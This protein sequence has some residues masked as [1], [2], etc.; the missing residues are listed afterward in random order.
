MVACR[1]SVLEALA[2]QLDH[3][4]WAGCSFWDMIQPSFMFLVGVAMPFSYGKRRDRG[5]SWGRLFG[6]AVVRSIVLILLGIFLQSHDKLHTDWTFF[7]V[8]MQI[9]LGYP[10]VFLVL[11]LH[12][13]FQLLAACAILGADWAIFA[14]YVPKS[15]FE[16]HWPSL[17]ALAG[18]WDK[19]VN[20]AWRFDRWFLNSLPRNSPF[21]HNPGG[22]ATLNFVP[23]IATMIFG[24]MAGRLLRS[25]RSNAVKTIV[26]I[27]SGAAGL[28]I[29]I[30]LDRYGIV[31]IVK[32]I[33]TPSWV[34]LRPAWPV[35]CSRGSS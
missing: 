2:F 32:R 17:H 11:E 15:S 28:A 6:H 3:V 25:D 10:F 23:S 26:L 7:G 13:F 35:G 27:V 1:E 14:S 9:G 20:F 31:P 34:F 19:N 30:A 16:F 8:L 12:P 18:H 21:D 22:Y 29:G 4:E 5:D 33:W 24:V